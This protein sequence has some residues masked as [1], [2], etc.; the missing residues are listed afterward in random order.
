MSEYEASKA[1]HQHLLAEIRGQLV[2][3]EAETSRTVEE[4][5]DARTNGAS[6]SKH[7]STQYE[8]LH[9]TM[10]AMKKDYKDQIDQTDLEGSKLRRRLKRSEDKEASIKLQNAKVQQEMVDE[11][12]KRLLRNN[13][14]KDQ[15]TKNKDLD[16]RQ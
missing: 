3:A 13:A 8:E 16:R 10:E 6:D 7:S 5:N 2:T 4:L 14:T 11:F 1:N 9:R 15:E 12:D